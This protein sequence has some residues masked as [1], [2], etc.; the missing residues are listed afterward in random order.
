MVSGLGNKVCDESV[1]NVL[2]KK[3]HIFLHPRNKGLL[4][5]KDFKERLKFSREIKGTF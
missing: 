4:K 1:K 5:P 2:K 3:G